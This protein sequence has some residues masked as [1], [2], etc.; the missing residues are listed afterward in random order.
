MASK[1]IIVMRDG[2][3][4][5]ENQGRE[6]WEYYFGGEFIFGTEYR[7]TEA[8]LQKLYDVGYFY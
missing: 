6:A 3:I 2:A 5:I 7:W 8:E 4:I 1:N